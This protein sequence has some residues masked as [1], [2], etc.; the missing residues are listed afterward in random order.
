M[1]V[2]V[3]GR[4]AVGTLREI[5]AFNQYKQS[6]SKGRERERERRAGLS[7]DSL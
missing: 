2:V 6:G 3:P 7:Y 4:L 1:N 5:P